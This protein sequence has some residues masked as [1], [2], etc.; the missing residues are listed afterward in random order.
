V[1]CNTEIFVEGLRER[2]KR[3]TRREIAETALGLF[4]ERG[5]DKVS[6]IEVARAA[7]VAE[8]TI[9]NYFPSKANLVF[10]E[11]PAVLA[12]MIDAV[13]H[14]AI[15][16]SAIGAVRK[17][18]ATVAS[19]IGDSPSADARASFQ[20]MVAGSETL[21][22]HQRLIVSRYER[23]LAAVLAD[24]TGVEHGSPE[25]VA[26]AIALVGALRAGYD[27]AN[28]SGGVGLAIDRALD[29]LEAGLGTYAAVPSSQ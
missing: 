19:Q 24:E 2:N 13:R 5:F 17:A 23:S 27:S 21:L 11:D 20:K 3:R 10:D 26:A 7:G 14:R 9:Y 15:G 22:A 8:K 29:L 6:V 18:L 28:V 25:P 4:I 12:A 1:P 16:E